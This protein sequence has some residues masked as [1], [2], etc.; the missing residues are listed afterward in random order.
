MSEAKFNPDGS[1]AEASAEM[2]DYYVAQLEAYLDGE[3]DADEAT[4][5]RVRLSEEPGYAA[6]LDR[7]HRERGDRV[8]AFESIEHYETDPA[9]AERL[10]AAARRLAGQPAVAEYLPSATA[11]DYAW[12]LWTK[13][14]LGMAAS[15]M[16]GFVG[17]LVGGYDF[18]APQAQPNPTPL[19]SEDRTDPRIRGTWVYY[20]DQ[21]KPQVQYEGSDPADM[22]LLPSD[23]TM[24]HAPR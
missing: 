5:V 2:F 23:R 13:V 3:L 7:L 21:G 14:A 1:P 4:A 11:R 6:A 10:V 17:G 24:E 22:G 8:R 12:P 18:G 20:D 9:A 16:V 19:V 15:V